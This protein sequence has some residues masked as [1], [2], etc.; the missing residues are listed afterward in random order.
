MLDI[1][2]TM[3]IFVYAL[4]DGTRVLVGFRNLKA[5][6][7]VKHQDMNGTTVDLVK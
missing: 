4:D 3:H 1:G 5:L 6:T 2:S 7:Y